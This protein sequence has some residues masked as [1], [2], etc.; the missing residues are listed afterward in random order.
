M[1]DKDIVLR[2]EEINKCKQ[3]L[4]KAYF[5]RKNPFKTKKAH[6]IFITGSE[7]SGRTTL[8]NQILIPSRSNLISWE[9]IYFPTIV[10]RANGYHASE[11]S[12]F[13]NSSVMLYQQL[14]EAFEVKNRGSFQYFNNKQKEMDQVR[15]RLTGFL[16]DRLSKIDTANKK[17][18]MEATA[19]GLTAFAGILI[20]S[21]TGNIPITLVLFQD[22][23]T[24]MTATSFEL[25]VD[26]AISY[27][28]EWEIANEKD[29][30]FLHGYINEVR[31]AFYKDVDYILN[32]AEGYTAVLF[33]DVDRLVNCAKDLGDLIEYTKGKLLW[34]FVGLKGKTLGLKREWRPYIEFEEIEVKSFTVNEIIRY[35]KAVRDAD[36]IS[37]SEIEKT[38]ISIH[39]ET[40]G[41]PEPTSVYLNLWNESSKKNLEF[42]KSY[43]SDDNKNKITDAIKVLI[44]I[45]DSRGDRESEFISMLFLMGAL[46]GET[47][48][49]LYRNHYLDIEYDILRTLGGSS[50]ERID[51]GGIIY[52]RD[53]GHFV[54][55]NV[56]NVHLKK[57]LKKASFRKKYKTYLDK[58]HHTAID[59]IT[60]K[61]KTITSDDIFHNESWVLLEFARCYHELWV[62][63]ERGWQDIVRI[64][65]VSYDLNIVFF[66]D[67]AKVLKLSAE[68]FNKDRRNKLNGLWSLTLRTNSKRNKKK[69]ADYFFTNLGV[70][71]EQ[72]ETLPH[73]PYKLGGQ[74]K[75]PAQ[76]P[77]SNSNNY[78]SSKLIGKNKYELALVEIEENINNK[79]YESAKEKIENILI[80]AD[81]QQKNLFLLNLGRI[82]LEEGFIEKTQ[83]IF[84]QIFS[85]L[86]SNKETNYTVCLELGLGYLRISEISGEKIEKSSP[87]LR[88]AELCLEQA[89]EVAGDNKF[90]ARMHLAKLKKDQLL[91][92]EAESYFLASAK[93]PLTPQEIKDKA[94]EEA[95]D[96]Q[97]V[98]GKRTLAMDS[99]GKVSNE[100]PAIILKKS[101]IHLKDGNRDFT[102]LPPLQTI[103]NSIDCNEFTRIQAEALVFWHLG[104]IIDFSSS[105]ATKT[106]IFKWI[107][108]NEEKVEALK[109]DICFEYVR[110]LPS[111]EK[112]VNKYSRYKKNDNSGLFVRHS[113]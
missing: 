15:D 29:I 75:T 33:D 16:Y 20:E 50:Y 37:D 73:I 34:V 106:R 55:Q 36:D 5:D 68:L 94:W 110:A 38:A 60:K 100:S 72:A 12:E 52:S 112:M 57:L 53:D 6:I 111:F 32:D 79:K 87:N 54:L 108:E 92:A 28:K 90:E 1:A 61:Q 74:N 41:L 21:L 63:D 84:D 22:L 48:K 56:W 91:W 3:F 4:K 69:V 78:D 70:S 83:K 113:E 109:T 27:Y 7:K 51:G 49:L 42:L 44:E 8:A 25:F 76:K 104:E 59:L 9:F 10:I 98:Q 46:S 77:F 58:A 24:K 65:W 62:D 80:D 97:I 85:D 13:Q 101:Y 17:E 35:M 30:M 81:L 64:L 31:R 14:K 26:R 43:L 103:M 23:F 102:L 107:E 40:G 19:K 18:I 93:Q 67:F 2:K 39:K 66:K 99:Y 86:K 45:Y 82:Y 105:D 96:I 11:K 71:H 47:Q 95:G 89:I 88:L